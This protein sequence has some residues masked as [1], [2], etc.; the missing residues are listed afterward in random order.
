MHNQNK[1]TERYVAFIDILG[2]KEA[3]YESPENAEKFNEIT[4]ALE[5]LSKVK[6]IAH[7]TVEHLKQSKEAIDQALGIWQDVKV[8][9]FSDNILISAAN[10]FVGL[11]AIGAYS[12]LV[13]NS[14]FAN[15]FFA[16]GG[17]TKGDLFESNGVVFGKALIDAYELESK[18]SIYPRILISSSIIDDVK[19]ATGFYIEQDF[20]GSYFLD[21]FYPDINKLKENWQERTGLNL[22][23]QQGKLKLIEELLKTHNQSVRSKLFWLAKYFNAKTA[24]HG[25]TPIEKLNL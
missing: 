25:I 12:C 16:R 8:T 21:V 24:N 20:D 5:H 22:D 6:D 10:N 14:L 4:T 17:I 13:Y 1:Y 9:T 3:V 2:F 11:M 15:G 23:L 19:K 18:T 7:T